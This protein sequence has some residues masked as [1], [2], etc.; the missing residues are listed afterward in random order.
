M[1]KPIDDP[2]NPEVFKCYVAYHLYDLLTTSLKHLL[3]ING[4]WDSG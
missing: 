2:V 3:Q 4:A 1:T